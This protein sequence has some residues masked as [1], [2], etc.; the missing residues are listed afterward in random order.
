MIVLCAVMVAAGAGGRLVMRLLAVTAGPGAQGRITEADQVVGRISVDGTLGFII[1]AGLLFGAASG[2]AYLLLR[3][4]PAPG[5]SPC[6]RTTPTSTWWGS[7]PTCRCCCSRRARSP[8]W[9]FPA[10]PRPS[11]TSSAARR[12]VGRDGIE[13]R[14][15]DAPAR[16][17][18]HT[19]NTMP[20]MA[21]SLVG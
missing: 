16:P 14:Q 10:S 1:F 8:L 6:A 7:P 4:W 19:R 11:S 12:V 21:T 18:S 2:A 9:P 5:W 13:P 15:P 20:A 17:T 3:R